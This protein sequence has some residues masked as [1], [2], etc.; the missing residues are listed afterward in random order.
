M[1]KAI[2]KPILKLFDV[3]SVPEL[4]EDEKKALSLKNSSFLRF[5]LFH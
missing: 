3:E 5:I 4:D 2:L 1:F